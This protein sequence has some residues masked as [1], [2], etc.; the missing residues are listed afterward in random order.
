MSTAKEYYKLAGRCVL[1]AKE[2]EHD[3]TREAFKAL[4]QFWEKEAH[5]AEGQEGN[6]ANV[7]VASAIQTALARD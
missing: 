6:A 4:A 5:R 1:W 7:E 2:A 3:R